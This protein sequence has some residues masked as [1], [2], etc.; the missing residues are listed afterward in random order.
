[1][2]PNT[3]V[4]PHSVT[5]MGPIQVSTTNIQLSAASSSTQLSVANMTSAQSTRN[6]VGQVQI[7]NMTSTAPVG[8]QQLPQQIIP[9]ALKADNQGEAGSGQKTVPLVQQPP[10][11]SVPSG[12]AP[13][14]PPLVS[15]PPCSSPGAVSAMRK[16]P[17]SPLSIA[18]V[19]G[20][21]AQAGVAVTATVD[22]QQRPVERPAQCTTG[23]AP[24]KVF[25]PPTS[26]AVQ[27][28]AP[29][30]RTAAAQ[31]SVT[32]PAVSFS[33]PIQVAV[34]KQ[35]V[36]QVSVAAPSSVSNSVKA[37]ASQTTVATV[38]SVSSAPLLSTIAP[39]QN[40]VSSN[41]AG[42]G[43]IQDVP[44]NTSPPVANLVGAPPSQS[45]SAP[46]E[47]SLPSTPTPSE[48]SQIGPGKYSFY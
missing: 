12:S 26:T 1:M 15:I 27:T 23:A 16:P 2:A 46:L 31:N 40:A 22:S 45:I 20:K 18:Q 25:H 29:A 9:G 11:R 33:I 21:P 17:M 44:P 3:T 34:P 41:V 35:I 24:P 6:T 30:A 7:A 36:S 32:L 14:Q 19:K 43:P 10:S 13:F 48:A 47:P 39:L 8:A 4:V 42:T 38:V 37:L 28:E 5:M